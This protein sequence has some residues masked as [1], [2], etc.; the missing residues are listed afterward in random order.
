VQVGLKKEAD[1]PDVP[2]M[3]EL[4][5]TEADRQVL[6]LMSSGSQIGR[7]LFAPPGVPADRIA[8]LRSAFDSMVK[9]R[10]FQ[11]AAA[12]RKL[13]VRPTAGAEVQ[14]IVQKVISYS[15]AVIDRARAVSGAKN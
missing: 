14:T 3:L 4:A 2:L 9:D 11:E 6:E 7:A 15:P 5:T 1:L 12:K 13:I 10:E 8:A